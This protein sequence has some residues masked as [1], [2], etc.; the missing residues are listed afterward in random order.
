MSSSSLR[1]LQ[2]FQNIKNCFFQAARNR[3]RVETLVLKT[4]QWSKYA[5]YGARFSDLYSAALRD[6][7]M[8]CLAI[9]RKIED[10]DED[11]DDEESEPNK[12][13]TG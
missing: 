4:S 2:Y 11:T 8:L 12:V 1:G 7:G 5:Q 10:L 13:D 9:Y 3:V 6:A